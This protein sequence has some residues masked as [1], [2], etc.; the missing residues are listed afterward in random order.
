MTLNDYIRFMGGALEFDDQDDF[1]QNL[2]QE[3]S[4]QHNDVNDD[5][6]SNNSD[7]QDFTMEQQEQ[8]FQ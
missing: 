1:E 3:Y 8:L 6:Q 7:F 5:V 2:Y 4:N